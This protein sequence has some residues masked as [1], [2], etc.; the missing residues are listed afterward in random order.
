MQPIDDYSLGKLVVKKGYKQIFGFSKGLISVNF[1]DNLGDAIK[2]IEKNQF[3]GVNYSVLTELASCWLA[4]RIHSSTN[5][6][7]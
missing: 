7:I 1:Y 5:F 4:E 3:A 6:I 2:G